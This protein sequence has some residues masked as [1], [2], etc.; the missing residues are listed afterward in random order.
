MYRGEKGEIRAGN[1]RVV[2]EPAESQENFSGRVIQYNLKKLKLL[3]K[4]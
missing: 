2:R 3:K 4:M 1:N